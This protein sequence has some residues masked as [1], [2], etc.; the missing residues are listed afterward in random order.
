MSPTHMSNFLC[1]RYVRLIFSE[2]LLLA[3]IRAFSNYVDLMIR[4]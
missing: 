4:F 3:N 1:C 2:L